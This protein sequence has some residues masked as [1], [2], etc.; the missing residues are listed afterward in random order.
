MFFKRH[1]ILLLLA[2]LTV[3]GALVPTFATAEPKV[4]YAHFRHRP[5]E[6]IVDERNMTM[7]SPL[8][9]IIEEAAEKIGYRIHWTISP[10]ARSIHDLQ[11]GKVD[12]VPRT[13][14]TS[15][16]ETLSVFLDLCRHKRGIFY[17]WSKQVKSRAFKF[18]R[19]YIN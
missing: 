3:Y 2:S 4:L 6:M 17:F 1:L 5:P 8:K 15:E 7:S 14:K 16:R 18:M 13:I 9:D 12:I 19:I 11:V 10:F